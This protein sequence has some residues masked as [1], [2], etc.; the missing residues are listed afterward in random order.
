MANAIPNAILEDIIA[1]VMLMKGQ[2]MCPGFDK[3]QVY[4]DVCVSVGGMAMSQ[5]KTF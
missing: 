5:N 1:D 2:S 3:M 4:E